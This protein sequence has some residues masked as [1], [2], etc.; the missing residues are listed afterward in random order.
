MKTDMNLKGTAIPLP[1]NQKIDRLKTRLSKAEWDKAE[2][3]RFN[4]EYSRIFN[5]KVNKLRNELIKIQAE[6]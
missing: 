2:Y 6:L 5:N 3:F 4:G 1:I